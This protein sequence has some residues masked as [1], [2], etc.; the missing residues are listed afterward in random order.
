MMVLSYP[1]FSFPLCS[2]GSRSTVGLVGK[3][4]WAQAPHVVPAED[5]VTCKLLHCT[6]LPGAC[7]GRCQLLGAVQTPSPPRPRR[8]QGR[9]ITNFGEN[10][11]LLFKEVLYL[12]LY[13]RP[14][15]HFFPR[16]RFVG[17]RRA[18]AHG[19]PRTSPASSAMLAP[20]C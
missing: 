7:V 5:T 13:I 17:C 8:G 16:K 6:C 20:S 19:G 11:G 18:E 1:R 12:V 14:L 3:V 10:V 2:P 4:L 9:A 15:M